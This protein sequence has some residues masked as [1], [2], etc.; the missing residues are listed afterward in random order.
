MEQIYVFGAGGH[1]KVIVDLIGRHESYRVAAIIDDRESLHGENVLGYPIIGRDALLAQDGVLKSVGCVVA[2]GANRTRQEISAW[3]CSNGFELITVI[4]PDS[5][6]SEHVTLD[7]G[8]MVCARAVVNAGAR[9]GQSVIL[10]SGCIVEHD[11]SIGDFAHIAPGA[12]V[13]GGVQ[14]GAGT[15]VGAGATVLPGI[16]IGEG[17]T[18]GAGAVVVQTVAAGSTVVGIP[19][20]VV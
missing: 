10:N 7:V 18:I 12:V 6:V 9:I 1:G 2:V 16:T 13:C 15:L 20:R 4:H 11:C 8:V 17:V 5:S 14:I 19:A 3:L